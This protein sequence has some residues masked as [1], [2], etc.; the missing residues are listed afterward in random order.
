MSKND[1]KRAMAQDEAQLRS[2]TTSEVLKERGLCPLV[3]VRTYGA[4]V[5]VG[6]LA[7]IDGQEVELLDAR[8]LWRWQGANTLHEAAL[9][10]VSTGFTRLSEPVPQLVLLSAIEVLPIAEGAAKS[11]TTSRWAQ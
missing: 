5:H 11:L 2:L 1:T 9:R 10:G 6:L 8:R 4:G 3:L 7:R